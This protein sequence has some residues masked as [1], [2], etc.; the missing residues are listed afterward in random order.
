MAVSMRQ[1][2][3]LGAYLAKQK[4][5][6]REKFP[7]VVELEPL[8][9]CNLACA[10]CG[11]IQYPAQIL[12]QRMPVEQAI[13]AIEEC[14]AP[15]VS[16]A[17]GEPL[18]HPEMDQIVAEL[19]RRKRFVYLCTNALLMVKKMDKFKPSPYF[20]W[21]VHIDG[22]RERHDASVCE[23]GV[24]DKAV[25]AIKEAKRRGFRVTT[26]TTFF[27]T[28][29]PQT[30]REVLDFLND[31]LEVDQMM[32]S[33]AYAYE[34]APDQEHFLGVKETNELFR[35]A[36]GEGNRKK[37]RLNHSPLFLDFL[38]GKVDYQ[39]TAWGI[40]SY[41]IFGWQK[42]CYLMSDGYVK[43][44]KELVEETDWSK[45][46]RGNDPRCANCMAHCGYEPSA[47]LATMSSLKETLRAA[48]GR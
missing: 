36:F 25:D 10:G 1:S 48:S 22:L 6:R 18:I 19:I 26:N 42:P 34:K 24:F 44:Y 47:V 39:C 15:M 38:E 43:T 41:S 3:R 13:G 5:A 40:P 28:D 7:L 29:T 27:N 30:V 23:E 4:L 14:G 9:A 31:D 11:K 2:L 45:Y 35:K 32:I 8:F 12:K 33:P 46:G 16:I 37:W 20:S 21:A 17:G